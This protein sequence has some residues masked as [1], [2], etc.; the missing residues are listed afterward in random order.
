MFLLLE[1]I[2]ETLVEL[3]TSLNLGTND[4]KVKR[5]VEKLRK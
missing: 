5:K 3:Y 4:S 2:V 1:I